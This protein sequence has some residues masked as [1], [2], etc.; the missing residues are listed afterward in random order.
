MFERGEGVPQNFEESIRFYRLAAEQGDASE[1]IIGTLKTNAQGFT[2]FQWSETFGI[3]AS[4]SATSGFNSRGV[5]KHYHGDYAG[6]VFNHDTGDNFLN[7]SGTET[8]IV[9]E[10]Q[11]PD[12][13]YEDQTQSYLNYR[14]SKNNFKFK[15]SSDF[16]LS[17]FNSLFDRPAN[18]SIKRLRELLSPPFDI[19]F[20]FHNENF[21][22]EITNIKKLI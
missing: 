5:E 22:V 6:R 14:K 15:F 21:S 19:C 17:K 11:T 20:F 1:G 2:D 3:D 7:T 13:D 4:A 8:N 10:Y 16:I 9:A 12:L 18:E